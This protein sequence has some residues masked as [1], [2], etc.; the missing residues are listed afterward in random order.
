MISFGLF[1]MASFATNSWAGEPICD[2][3]KG[4][5][6]ALIKCRMKCAGAENQSN[7]V[8]EYLNSI[9]ADQKADS[10]EVPS[11]SDYKANPTDDDTTS[12]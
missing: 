4:I 9:G 3:E 7:G 12:T 2:C 1:L 6:L 10:G 5:G 8:G 11:D